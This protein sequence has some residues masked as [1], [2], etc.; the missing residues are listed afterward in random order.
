MDRCSLPCSPTI[1]PITL[2]PLCSV[3]WLLIFGMKC[4]ASHGKKGKLSVQPSGNDFLSLSERNNKATT[5]ILL[6]LRGCLNIS[7]LLSSFMRVIIC[8]RL[9]ASFTALQL[10]HWR[11]LVT[12]HN[13]KALYIQMES[14]LRTS[15]K[16][17]FYLQSTDDQS[18]VSIW[19]WSNQKPPEPSYQ[20]F[21][22]I[23]KASTL[24]IFDTIT[25]SLDHHHTSRLRSTP[26]WSPEGF[27]T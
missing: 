13:K 3:V 14:K 9:K 17:S 22:N 5:W 4:H 2:P 1:N 21:M 20:G 7:S 10:N 15:F 19:P 18:S 23:L 16:N 27:F 6:W 25:A 8:W 11:R 26:C 24:E 12:Y